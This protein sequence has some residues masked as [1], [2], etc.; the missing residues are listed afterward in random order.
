VPLFEVAAEEDLAT[1]AGRRAEALANLS[2]RLAALDRGR[3]LLGD[4]GGNE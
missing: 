3:R 4:Q 1:D 2:R